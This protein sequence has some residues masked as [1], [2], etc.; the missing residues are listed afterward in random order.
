VQGSNLLFFADPFLE[1]QLLRQ[2]ALKEVGRGYFVNGLAFDDQHNVSIDTQQ[3][4]LLYQNAAEFASAN[5]ISLGTALSEAQQNTLDR[6]LLWYVEQKVKQRDA[7]GKT[8]EITALVPTVYLP[9][10]YTEQTQNL[11]GGL[12]QG[13]QVS[14]TTPGTLR[15]TGFIVG[16]DVSINAG[17]FINEKRLADIGTRTYRPNSEGYFKVTGEAV[18]AGGFLSAANLT[19]NAD[20]VASVSGEFQI[21]AET[22]E[23]S[24]TNTQNLLANL[25]SELGA[26]FTESTVTDNLHQEWV[27]TKDHSMEQ[28]AMAV[29]AIAVAVM[30]GGAGAYML[31]LNGGLGATIANAAFSSMASSVVTGAISG[32]LSLENVLKSGVT[33]GLTAGLTGNLGLNNLPGNASLGDKLINWGAKSF[34]SAGVNTAINGGSFQSAFV[35]SFVSNAAAGA[36]TWIGDT[37]N[38]STNDATF[39]TSVA[40][41]IGHA[42]LGCAAA[43]AKGGDCEAGAIGAAASAI[44]SNFLAPSLAYDANTNSV[45]ADN[46]AGN[47]LLN[48][49]VPT[50]GALAAQAAGADAMT[51][52]NAA[53][54][55]WQNN[56]LLHPTEIQKIAT[57]AGNWQLLNQL[58][59]LNFTSQEDA[60]WRLTA[61]ACGIARCAAGY[62]DAPAALA[63]MQTLGERWSFSRE[64]SLLANTRDDWAPVY[65]SV[66]AGARGGFRVD[67]SADDFAYTTGDRV[68]DWWDRGQ[69]G[70]RAVGA[71]QGTASAFGAATSIVV[72]GATCIETLGLGCAAGY[73]GAV[74]SVDQMYA[75]YSTMWSGTP[76]LTFGEYGLQRL[77]LSP[78]AAALGYGLLG[79]SPMAAE[80]YL[81]NRATNAWAASNAAGR[82]T[83]GSAT[84]LS[85]LQGLSPAQVVQQANL[86]GLGTPRDGLLLWSGFGK[87]G[88]AS[89]QSYA[90]M[91]GGVTLEMTPGG[92]WLNQMDLYGPNSPFTRAEADFIWARASESL[93]GKASGQVRSVLGDVRPTSIYLR[94][95]V[96]GLQFN[97]AVTGLD[98]LNLRPGHVTQMVKP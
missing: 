80:A 32:D 49:L 57:L 53:Q 75:G 12:I 3:Q 91:N 34:V 22:Q 85:P 6:P 68:G 2:A 96:P 18:Q 17:E 37:F 89:S 10:L 69:I 77:G 45:H 25:R 26:N 95:E 56:R 13:D 92:A 28:I 93:V 88:P 19:L 35:N 8:E 76:T 38:I 1:Q 78:G 5:N 72:G 82:E 33:G 55:E 52:F 59:G 40:H 27:Q 42:A 51:G 58:H 70:T 21:L 74:V 50:L 30:T 64:A 48:T 24:Q 36:A 39:G 86:L 73:A 14:I 67:A 46:S 84:T 29:V 60:Q 41:A 20:R 66:N 23:Q 11:A 63:N 47:I 54:N 65:Q 62:A 90:R 44:A 9:K 97:P 7:D 4:A 83:Y 87:D 43:V 94:N 16:N 98:A 31:G 71:V 79:M 61:A 15:N 81:A